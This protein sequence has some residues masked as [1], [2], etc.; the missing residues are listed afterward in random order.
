MNFHSKWHGLI[1]IEK[2]FDL[3]TEL[4]QNSKDNEI[5]LVGCEHNEVLSLGKSL[6]QNQDLSL[7]ERKFESIHKTERGG[8]LT[9]HNPG[10]LIIYPIINLKA[11]QLTLKKYVCLLIKSSSESLE[12]L[13][14]VAQCDTKNQIGVYYENNKIVSIGLRYKKGWVSHGLSINVNNDLN[15]FSYFDICGQKQIKMTSLKNLGINITAEDFF[16]RW[17]DNFY[18]NIFSNAETI[19]QHSLVNSNTET[20][21]VI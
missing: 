9:L 7:F 16:K 20:S 4:L 12:E 13:G 15:K 1:N 21:I 5:N 6:W 17:T 19:L 2:G 14:L 3:Q 10:Q 18:K 11:Q 8:K